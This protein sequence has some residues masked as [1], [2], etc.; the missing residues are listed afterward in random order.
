MRVIAIPCLSDN[1]AY[2]VISGTRAAVVDPS[3]AAPIEAALA[4]EG[5]TLAAI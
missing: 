1:F 3:E 5:V 2:L 4:K